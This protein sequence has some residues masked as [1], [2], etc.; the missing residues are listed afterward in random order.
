MLI[1]M[2]HGNETWVVS[3]PFNGKLEVEL[4]KNKISKLM[5]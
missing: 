3:T 2:V 4:H 1:G 5:K